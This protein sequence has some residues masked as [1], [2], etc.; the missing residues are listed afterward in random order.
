MREFR[1][2]QELFD[3]LRGVPKQVTAALRT[4]GEYLIGPLQAAYP[5]WSASDRARPGKGARGYNRGQGPWY[6]TVGG[7]LHQYRGSS[8][9]SQQW[10]VTVDEPNLTATVGNPVKY[11]PFVM[12]NEKQSALHAA[13]GWPTTGRVK[14]AETG[15]ILQRFWAALKQALG[16]G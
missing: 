1:N 8:D 2:S 11:G 9:L 5:T 10:S 4:A 7:A 6:R 15:N 16:A 12:G 3:W 13:H 14:E